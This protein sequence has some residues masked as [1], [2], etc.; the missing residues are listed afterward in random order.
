VDFWDE[1]RGIIFGGDWNDKARNTKNK[2]LTQ[3]GG[4]TW[5]LVGEG[6]HPGYRSCVQYLDKDELIAVGSTG[7]S[8]SGDAG[9]TW[10]SIS[11]EGFY[12]ARYCPCSKVIW[13]AGHKK[14][15]KLTFEGN[16]CL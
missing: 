11:E 8:Y 14:M 1:K 16:P 7:I 10:R 5:Q 6:K 2:A 12:T 3:D 13:L 9:K 15:G 4:K